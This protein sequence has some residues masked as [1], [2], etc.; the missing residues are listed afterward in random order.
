MSKTFIIDLDGTL[1]KFCPHVVNK[2]FGTYELL[3]GVAQAILDAINH[4]D[5]V[6]FMTARP[7]N[8]RVE[9]ERELRNLGLTWQQIVMGAGGGERVIV[10]DL[11]C[12]AIRVQQNKGFTY[13][14][15][16]CD[17]KHTD[18]RDSSDSSSR[19]N[20][21]SSPNLHENQQSCWAHTPIS[22]K[23]RGLRSPGSVRRPPS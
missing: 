10:N 9:V 11:P 23:R 6:I 3:P 7:E 18:R 1:I 17:S 21:V 15:I 4:G 2:I 16:N 8:M 14:E 20:R 12:K 22:T 5:K 13:D 19:E